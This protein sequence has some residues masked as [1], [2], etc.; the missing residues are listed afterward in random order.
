MENIKIIGPYKEEIWIQKH[1]TCNITT[2]RQFC[3]K[4]FGGRCMCHIDTRCDNC[5][6]ILQK[7]IGLHSGRVLVGVV[8]VV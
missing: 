3:P 1:W 7:R 5:N 8:Y 2:G 4:T 6:L